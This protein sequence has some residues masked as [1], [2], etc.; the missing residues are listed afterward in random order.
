MPT[1]DWSWGVLLS[2][3]V[4]ELTRHTASRET[5]K[6]A[7][8]SV[9]HLPP[10]APALGPVEEE[11][12]KRLDEA[13]DRVTFED[14]MSRTR[15]HIA[16]RIEEK[17]QELRTLVDEKV[18]GLHQAPAPAGGGEGWGE[19]PPADGVHRDGSEREEVAKD[20]LAARET[21][22]LRAASLLTKLELPVEVAGEGSER[23]DP[24]EKIMVTSFHRALPMRALMRNAVR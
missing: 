10:G 23:S 13:M 21:W 24:A 2:N 3:A 15:D 11:F 6:A 7:P 1:S 17:A 4:D 20:Q 18:E 9:L 19:T 12:R 5:R 22:L 8:L 14:G 16:F